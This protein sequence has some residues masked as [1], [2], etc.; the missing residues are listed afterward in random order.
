MKRL[1]IALAAALALAAVASA[2]T[3]KKDVNIKASDGVTL[4]GTVSWMRAQLLGH[5]ATD[6]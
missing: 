6:R 3:Q 5:G 4:R 1:A 2:D